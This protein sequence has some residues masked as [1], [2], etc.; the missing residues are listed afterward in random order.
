MCNGSGCSG[1]VEGVMAETGANR[2]AVE[3]AERDDLAA[4]Y[5]RE[6]SRLVK[7]ALVLTDSLATAEEIVQDA[8]V[9][10]Q[11]TKSSVRNPGGYLRTSVVNGC[12]DVQR[13]R[14]VVRRT[15]LER[16]ELVVAEYDELFD[17]LATLSWRQQTALVLRFHVDLSEAEIGEALGCKPA[18]VR[19]I[20]SRAL[21][22]LRK[23]LDS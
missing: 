13:H 14:A 18:F 5:E 1:V 21:A 22:A 17:A 2:I 3:Q 23:E 7:V 11:S 15:P 19:S 4:L 20:I 6:W 12:R 10:L 8:F 9:K 16:S